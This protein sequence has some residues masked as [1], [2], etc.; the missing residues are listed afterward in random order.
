MKKSPGTAALLVAQL[1]RQIQK[2]ALGNRK[3]RQSQGTS[4][5][6][7]VHSVPTKKKTVKPAKS[8]IRRTTDVTVHGLVAMA[9]RAGI[10]RA[11]SNLIKLPW[12]RL[13]SSIASRANRR[14]ASLRVSAS[15]FLSA[16]TR[17]DR[18][19][20]SFHYC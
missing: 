18:S 10:T 7:V 6:R 2:R 9:A 17:K 14:M 20:S 13:T 16:S 19:N 5:L 15:G 4:V 3:K 1:S 8:T 11:A 12:T